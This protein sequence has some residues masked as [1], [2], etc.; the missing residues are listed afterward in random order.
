MVHIGPWAATFGLPADA[1][2]LLPGAP[3]VL[4]G[5]YRQHGVPTAPSNEAFELWLKE[6]RADYGLRYVED[7]TAAA[8]GFM[9]ER[10]VGMPANNLILVYRRD[11]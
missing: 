8:E 9:L 1:E 2:R 6:K 11:A 3:L 10:I 7:V 5:P 4:Y